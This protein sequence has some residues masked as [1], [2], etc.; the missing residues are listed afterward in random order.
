MEKYRAHDKLT[1]RQQ[2]E[3]AFLVNA[4]VIHKAI[5]T[6]YG[7]VKA[8][9]RRISSERNR[10]LSEDEIAVD[11]LSQYHY[12]QELYSDDIRPRVRILLEREV[13]TP[14]AAQAAKNVKHPMHNYNIFFN[15]LFQDTPSLP[16]YNKRRKKGRIRRRNY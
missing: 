9:V 12:A 2:E 13:L 10:W 16:E 5:A 11:K 8:N 14:I 3:V 6:T 4:G 7:T 15:N 1:G